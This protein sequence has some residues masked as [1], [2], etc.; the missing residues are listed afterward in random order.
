MPVVDGVVRM[1]R[2]VIFLDIF[3]VMKLF[4]FIKFTKKGI[5]LTGKGVPQIM[6]RIA[7]AQNYVPPFSC[8]HALWRRSTSK[9]IETLRLRPKTHRNRDF[10]VKMRS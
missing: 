1:Q 9:C 6:I 2:N 5:D 8:S 10:R 3:S 7:I 4:H